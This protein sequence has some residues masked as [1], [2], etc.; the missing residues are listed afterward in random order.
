MSRAGG[1]VVVLRAVVALLNAGTGGDDDC[2]RGQRSTRRLKN[3][4]A[5]CRR[6]LDHASLMGHRCM[7]RRGAHVAN[8]T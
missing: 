3:C 2:G 7:N 6:L 4:A 8:G 5:S 1:D